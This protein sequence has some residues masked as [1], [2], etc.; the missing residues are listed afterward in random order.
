[1]TG[2]INRRIAVLGGLGI[3]GDPI[4]KITNIKRAGG[5]TQVVYLSRKYKALNSN[6][7]TAKK[8]KKGSREADQS[9]FASMP[10]VHIKQLMCTILAEFSPLGLRS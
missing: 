4:S 10:F 6:P 9:I 5:V 1:M 8:K 7:S 3:K 2:S